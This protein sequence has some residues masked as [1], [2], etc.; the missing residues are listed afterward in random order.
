[1]LSSWQTM[2]VTMT[3]PFMFVVLAICMIMS[4]FSPTAFAA[5]EKSSKKG[6]A[7]CHVMWLDV[8]RTQKETLIKWQPGNVLMKDTQGIVSSEEVCYSCHDG[9]VAD[10]RYTVWKYNN[11][12]IFKKPSRNIKIPAALTL[13]NKDE[14]YCGTCHSP[15]AGRTTAP[16]SSPE[17]TIPGLL[18]FLRLPNV[19]SELC[20][21]CHVNEADFKRT[22]GH[23]VHTHK[24][25]IPKTLFAKGSVK[26]GEKNTVICQTCHAV[27]G[28]KGRHLTVMDNSQSELCMVCHKER[29]IV[30]TLHDVRKTMPEE[31]NLRGQPVSES[32]PCGAC[33]VP[34]KSEGYKL[35]ARE[36]QPGK[37]ASRICLSC[38]TGAPNSKIK[39]IGR[40]SHPI[41]VNAVS[42]DQGKAAPGPLSVNLPF[43][44]KSGA[45][46]LRGL[47]QCFTCH[48]V[49]QW[50]PNNLDNKGGKNVA[51]NASNSFLRMSG[52][53]SSALCVA[54]HPDK[55]QIFLFDH[56]LVLTAPK[57]KNIRGETPVVSGPCGACHIP[58]NAAGKRLWA[59]KVSQGKD[60]APHYCTGCHSQNGAAKEKQ[61]GKNDHPVDAVL[62]GRDIPPP[63][64][65]T[66]MLPLY[67]T[68]GGTEFGDRMMCGT[69]HDP[70]IWSADEKE[71]VPVDM[72]A[73]TTDTAVKNV[74][75]DARNSFLRKAASPTPDLCVVCHEDTALLT[76]TDHDFFV[77]APLS[78]NQIGQTVTESGRCGVCHAAHNSPKDRLL[79]AQAYG[80]VEKNQHPMNSLCT[81]CHS[82]SGMAKDKVPAVATH[83]KG[84]LIDN[85]FTF[86][87][88][89]TGYIKIF[90]DHWKEVD[91]GDLSCSSCHSFYQWDHRTSKPGP[92]NNVE[93]NADTSFLRTSSGKTVCIDCHG[94]TAIWRYTYFHSIQKRGM[95]KEKK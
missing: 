55:R 60:G 36:L 87:N 50:D 80:P 51:G 12:P 84:K 3:K 44:S 46:Q 33:H 35:W 73:R 22:K 88:Q 18:S 76:G 78:K 49:H 68:E 41:D 30:G 28:T 69:C 16:G 62:K 6:C 38:H 15:H 57:A 89:G 93:G 94:E 91:V 19:D 75:G 34:H 72:P 59:R 43:F 2:T 52:T 39:S 8:F 42:K 77:T 1:M 20:E 31:T 82:K 85:I 23:P 70:H 47:I 27:H 56:N 54:C 83:P 10:S 71:T 65:V 92:G 53:H 37:S 63:D 29:T 5:L 4:A 66:E 64:C 11:H 7:V 48:N 32:G 9:Y 90:D 79:W 58:H 17:E 74:E 25:K 21:A 86:T 95:L 13:S 67:N 81:G 61:V 14:I 26:A 24:L 40:Y 45:R